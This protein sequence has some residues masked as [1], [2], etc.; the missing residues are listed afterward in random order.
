MKGINMPARDPVLEQEI[1]SNPRRMKQGPRYARVVIGGRWPEWE[2]EVLRQAKRLNSLLPVCIDY[3]VTVIKGAWPELEAVLYHL[4]GTKPRYR[5]MLFSTV[6]GA[7]ATYTIDPLGGLVAEYARDVI[8]GQWHSFE[9]LI[10]NGKCRLDIAVTYTALFRGRPWT[11]LQKLLLGAAP[12]DAMVALAR[13]A[14][15]VRNGKWPAAEKY[16]LN[17]PSEKSLSYA[18]YLYARHALKGELPANL[19]A[20]MMFVT[21]K[22]PNNDWKKTYLNFLKTL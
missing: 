4:A 8:K 13:Y 18:L 9:S 20:A 3:A 12:G 5:P 22:D 19:H 17:H 7:D 15:E 2:K 6:S 11:A 21:H 14:S 10:L 1:L 16:F